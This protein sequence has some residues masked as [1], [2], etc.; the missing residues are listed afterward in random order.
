M[1][2]PRTDNALCV[3][4]VLDSLWPK[5]FGDA[6][7]DEDQPLGEGGLGLDSIEIVELVLECQGRAGLE[8]NR[9]DELLERG[10]LTIG[11]LIDHLGSE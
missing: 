4:D 3:Q 6:R 5:R 10:P 11:G 8:G 7:R 1:T 9:A 2:A